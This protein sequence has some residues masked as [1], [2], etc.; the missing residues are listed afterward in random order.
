[1]QEIKKNKIK[2]LIQEL[3]NRSQT[4]TLIKATAGVLCLKLGYNTMIGTIDWKIIE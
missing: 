3:T 1:M 2:T 4:C